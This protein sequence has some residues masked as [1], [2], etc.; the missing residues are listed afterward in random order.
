MVYRDT[1]SYF[2]L[3]MDDNNRKPV[4]RLHFNRSKKY[5]GLLDDKKT[6]TRHQIEG[7]DGIYES[8]DA[9]RD[10]AQRYF[11]AAPSQAGESGPGSMEG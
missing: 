2:S 3:L 5:I 1:K 8:A 6:E 9:L 7:P 4:C 11:E 10:T